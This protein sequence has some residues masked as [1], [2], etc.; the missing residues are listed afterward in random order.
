MTVLTSSPLAGHSST[1]TGTNDCESGAPLP[2]VESLT[3]GTTVPAGDWRW[4]SA[5]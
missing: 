2:T 4:Q 1:D 3:G 5:V